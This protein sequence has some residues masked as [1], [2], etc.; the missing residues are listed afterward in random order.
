MQ[1]S[2]VKRQKWM[3]VGLDARLTMPK[4]AIFAP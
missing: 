3:N 2:K 4:Y 1:N